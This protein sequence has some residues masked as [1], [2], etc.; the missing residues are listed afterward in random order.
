M[1]WVR[2]Q[3]GVWIF[4]NPLTWCVFWARL[5][6]SIRMP[7]IGNAEMPA[8]WLSGCMCGTLC[9]THFLCVLGDILPGIENMV[10]WYL[11][12]L[13]YNKQQQHQQQHEAQSGWK[14]WSVVR[15]KL[16]FYWSDFISHFPFDAA[17]SSVGP[18]AWWVRAIVVE[19]SLHSQEFYIFALLSN[20]SAPHS[21]VLC[22]S[23]CRESFRLPMCSNAIPINLHVLL[24]Y[25]GF[26][27]PSP[28]D[29]MIAMCTVRPGDHLTPIRSY[30]CRSLPPSSSFYIE[31]QQ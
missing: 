6:F 23:I 2:C 19:L 7:H 20:R 26:F 16:S 24:C 29:G 5:L 9:E 28:F 3:F 11:Q 10:R 13:K 8:R 30:R 27:R 21:N 22:A 18:E 31:Q 4:T 17:R 1:L 14:F 12:A 25:V 15:T